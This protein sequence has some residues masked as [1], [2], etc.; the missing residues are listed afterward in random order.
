MYSNP[1]KSIMSVWNHHWTAFKLKIGLPIM[2][3]HNEILTDGEYVCQ[4]CG[5]VLEKDY[6]KN[7]IYF[8]QIQ[9]VIIIKM[10]CIQI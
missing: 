3:E 9:G 8:F 6:G 4:Y 2:C 7:N 5:L 10:S 1:E